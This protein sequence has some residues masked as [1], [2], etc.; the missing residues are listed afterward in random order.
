MV[1]N[2]IRVFGFVQGVFFRY[3]A[4]THADEL[5][6]NGYAKNLKD[7]SV[8]IVVCGNK[9]KI[10]EFMKW[11]Q[12]GSPLAQVERIESKEIEFQKYSDFRIQ[13]NLIS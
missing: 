7:E 4:K 12:K 9:E 10:D 11:C 8:E 13:K 5:G 6:L 1:C 2:F 3:S